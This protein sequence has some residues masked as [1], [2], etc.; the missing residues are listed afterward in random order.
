MVFQFFFL[1]CL[2]SLYINSQFFIVEAP[3]KDIY[4]FMGTM[5]I[6]H[7]GEDLDESMDL[8][9]TIWHNTILASGKVIA[10]VIYTGKDTRASMNQN[11]S[12]TKV[13]ILDNEVNYF[14]KVNHRIDKLY[15]PLQLNVPIALQ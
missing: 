2:S 15:F 8:E 13:G 5:Y 3:K 11:A 4:S 10:I 12:R 6:K 7:A 1:N 14:A 9:N